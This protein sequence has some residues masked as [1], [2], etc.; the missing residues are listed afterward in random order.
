[1]TV[2]VTLKRRKKDGYTDGKNGLQCSRY[3][4]YLATGKMTVY[5]KA[6]PDYGPVNGSA[7]VNYLV[8]KLGWEKCKKEDGAIFS[9]PVRKGMPYGHTGMVLNAKKNQVNDANWTKPLTVG[10]HTINL[11]TY[12][13]TYCRPKTKKS[14]TT[15]TTPSTKSTATYYT[16]KKGDTLGA[17][18]VKYRTTVPALAKLNNIKNV[19]LI[20][21]G[22]KV[23]IK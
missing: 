4:A 8:N 5:S 3:A 10:T 15:K 2:E 1:M 21:V 12:G 14:A 19:N 18:A 20:R 11:D 22:Q 16:V 17:I 7:M 23:R 9:I 13:A 6:H